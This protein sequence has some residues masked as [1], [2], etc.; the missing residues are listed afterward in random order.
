MA[1]ITCPE[2]GKEMSDQADACPHCGFAVRRQ[3][4]EATVRRYKRHHLAWMLLFLTGSVLTIRGIS[5]HFE[6]VEM[7]LGFLLGTVSFIAMILSAIRAWWTH[8]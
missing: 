6:P 7:S 2:C 5:N 8:A 3:V 1:L 4:V